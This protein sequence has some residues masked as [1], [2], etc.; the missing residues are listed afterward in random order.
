ML[1]IVKETECTKSDVETPG[2][3]EEPYEYPSEVC[4]RFDYTDE[5]WEYV[6]CCLIPTV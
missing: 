1:I 5:E 3:S 6:K 4:T 2:S